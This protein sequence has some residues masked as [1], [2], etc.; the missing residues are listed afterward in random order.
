MYAV[1]MDDPDEREGPGDLGLSGFA[2]KQEAQAAAEQHAG[3]SLYWVSETRGRISQNDYD[4]RAYIIEEE[5][6]MTTTPS[7]AS[8]P[9]SA[10]EDMITKAVASQV[11]QAQVSRPKTF[12]EVLSEVDPADSDAALAMLDFLLKTGRLGRV[13]VLDGGQG[14]LFMYAEP[15]G[16]T[17]AGYR[18]GATQGDRIV[19]GALQ[20]QRASGVPASEKGMCTGCLSVVRKDG[21]VVVDDVTGSPDCSGSPAGHVMA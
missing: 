12:E 5:N 2:S 9:L 6:S 10:L 21:D 11:G 3:G 18:P 13:G 17:K 20:E 7:E 4:P 15:K 19:D 16:T 8:V 1:Y 14:Y